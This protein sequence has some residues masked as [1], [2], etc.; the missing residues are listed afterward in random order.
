MRY[1]NYLVILC[2]LIFLS[3]CAQFTRYQTGRTLGKGNTMIGAKA[4][5]AG[6]AV[7]QPG[8]TAFPELGAYVQYGII[9]DLDIGVSISSNT[10]VMGFTKYQFLGDKYSKFAGSIE[11]DVESVLGG[12]ELYDGT[13]PLRFAISAPLSM[14]QNNFAYILQPQYLNQQIVNDNNSS[15]F[16]GSTFGYYKETQKRFDFSLGLTYMFVYNQNFVK[17]NENFYQAGL[18]FHFKSKG[19]RQSAPDDY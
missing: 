16:L 8:L 3:S 7:N 9:D 12:N 15:H 1:C 13:Y 18:V 6:V 5:L 11:L 14:H 19:M 17:T 2:G 4:S 10:S